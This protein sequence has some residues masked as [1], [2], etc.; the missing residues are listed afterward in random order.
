MSALMVNGSYYSPALASV[1]YAMLV[2]HVLYGLS[3]PE[4][5]KEL[6]GLA[7]AGSQ[8]SMNVREF[9][10]HTDMLYQS[11][12]GMLPTGEEEALT[13]FIS[14]LNAP[15][16]RAK[17]IELVAQQQFSLL[18][19]GEKLEELEQVEM[20]AVQSLQAS[21]SLGTLTAKQQQAAGAASLPASGPL[22]S[23]QQWQQQQDWRA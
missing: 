1:H 14:G 22:S 19:L 12:K 2:M 21:A 11:V 23:K 10:Q 5:P 17:G 6:R 8:G 15:Y 9:A 16:L 3:G 4:Q 20:R 18:Q 7:A 13:H